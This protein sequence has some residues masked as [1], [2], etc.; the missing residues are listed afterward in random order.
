MAM[1]EHSAHWCNRL[2]KLAESQHT[3]DMTQPQT[4]EGDRE[5]ERF[6]RKQRE[7]TG[8]AGRELVSSA[9]YQSKSAFV[10]TSWSR[11]HTLRHI[12]KADRCTTKARAFK[13]II[14]TH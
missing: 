4:E 9:D 2:G 10:S 6:G 12:H 14:Q 3:S 5:R 11:S 7:T 8:A 13:L 1:M